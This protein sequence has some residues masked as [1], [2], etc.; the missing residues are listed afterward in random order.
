MLIFVRLIFVAAI[1]YKNIFT[2]KISRFTV[3]YVMRIHKMLISYVRLDHMLYSINY[4][5]YLIIL[6]HEAARLHRY[7]VPVA[8]CVVHEG[9]P[10]L[11]V[12]KVVEYR[13]EDAVHHVQLLTRA[14]ETC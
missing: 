7:D 12:P 13:G 5:T 4:G 9:E 8:P 6:A 14:V 3:H 1:D 2:T 11:I 10:R